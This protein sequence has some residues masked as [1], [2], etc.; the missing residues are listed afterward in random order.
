MTPAGDTKNFLDLSY[1]ELE[2]MNL[3]ARKLTDPEKA[4]QQHVEYL[5]AEPR[6]KAV[7]VCFSNIEGRLHMLDYDKKFLLD[8]LDNL[9]F[10]GSSIRGFSELSESDLRLVLDWTSFTHLPADVF[11]P[12]KV[13]VFA[14]VAGRDLTPYEAD[15]RGRLQTYSREIKASKGLEAFM[16]PELEGFLL[17]GIDAEQLFKTTD[18]FKLISTG[19]Y[20]HSLPLDRLRQFID[21][22]AEAQRALG[23][24][25]EKDH[26]E[27]A[28]SQFEI[29]FS[30]TDA[31]RACDQVQLYK[32]TCRQI[33]NRLGMTATFLPKPVQ[34][35]NGSGMHTNFSLSK[36]GKNAFWDPKGQDGVSKLAWDVIE[37][38]LNRAPEICL[39]LNSSVNAYRRLDP[40][41][42][43][44][45]QIKVSAN[46]R[47]SMIRI[48]FGNERSARIEIRSVAPDTNPYLLMF[49]LLKV[50]LE[51]K[52]PAPESADKRSRLRFLPG[53]LKDAM[54]LFKAS[55]LMGQIMG[56]DVKEKFLS[57]KQA[58]ADRNPRELGTAIKDSEIL[59][60]HEVT[61][62][63]LWNKF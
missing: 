51:D 9:T 43:A 53:T 63:Y 41:F 52:K 34:G 54:R 12:G 13:I 49:T 40:N 8:S 5:R 35:I 44:P 28:P 10:D 25:N 60:H 1:D 15:F 38:V 21:A 37:K 29:N 56:E 26:P 16:A 18:D 17:E 14:N 48:P 62:Q 22:T 42:E 4:R 47:G 20:Y 23:F 50:G 19:G 31:V 58:T 46:D 61:N 59:Y 3:A 30:Y 2:S 45:N 55:D 11:G 7:T 24:R 6:L 32:L 57:Y 39:V 27:V 33:A 36:N